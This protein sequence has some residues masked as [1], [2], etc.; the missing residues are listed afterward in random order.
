MLD[1]LR[2]HG[3]VVEFETCLDEC[4]RCESCAFALASG[5]MV[6]APTPEELVAKLM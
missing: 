3:Y 1:L 6:F 2:G 5:R 4:T